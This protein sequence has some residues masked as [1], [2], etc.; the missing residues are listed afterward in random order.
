MKSLRGFGD[1]DLNFKG[2]IGHTLPN[3]RQNLLVCTVS[4]ELLGS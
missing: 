3:L 1:L 2:T 4:H